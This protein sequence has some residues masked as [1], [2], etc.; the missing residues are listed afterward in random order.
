MKAWN[1]TAPKG[2]FVFHNGAR[3]IKDDT[4]FYD[5]SCTAEYVR[6]SLIS[7]DGYN[8]EIIVTKGS[9]K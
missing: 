7:H 8:P 6:E 5:D 9:R 4:V 1:V 2:Q 3:P